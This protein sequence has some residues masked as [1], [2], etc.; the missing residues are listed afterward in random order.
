MLVPLFSKGEDVFILF[1]KRAS[2]VE[3]HKG[4][5]SFPGGR[6]Q[7]SDFSLKETA[8]REAEEEIGLKR[9][10]VILLG[11]LDDAETLV[12]Y[13]KI[14]PYVAVFTYPYKLKMNENEVESIF[15]LPLKDF[16]DCKN[17]Y[18]SDTEGIIPPYFKIQ[19]KI[20][21]GA[22]AMIMTNYLSIVHPG[23]CI[24]T[25]KPQLES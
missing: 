13:F 12:S 22:T 21:W 18:T 16:L 5:I 2:S 9:E 17:F 3:N 15:E 24:L 8:L 23:N 20:I 10:D 4:Q 11:E 1:T 19:D 6:F 7:E 25:S 14:C